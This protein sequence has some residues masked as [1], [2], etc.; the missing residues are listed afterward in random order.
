[1]TFFA[2]DTNYLRDTD[3]LPRLES[4]GPNESFVLTDTTI[5]ETMK[6]PYWQNVARNSFGALAQHVNKMVVARAPGKLMAGEVAS[7][8]P[9][10]AISDILDPHL[11]GEFRVLAGE[12]AG[13][14]EGQAVALRKDADECG[15]GGFREGA[16]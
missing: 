10:V 1:M 9:I 12:L 13:G 7:K 8:V 16:A 4:A 5:L 14:I 2:V 11:T 6:T 3:F 15:S